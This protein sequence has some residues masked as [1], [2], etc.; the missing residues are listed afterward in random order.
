M[1]VLLVLTC[2]TTLPML[3]LRA[4]ALREQDLTAIADAGDPIRYSPGELVALAHPGAAATAFFLV[5]AGEVMLLP[6][7]LQIPPGT[8]QLDVSKVQQGAVTGVV[9]LVGW[10]DQRKAV[11]WRGLLVWKCLLQA[12]TALTCAA[13]AGLSLL[14]PHCRNMF[15]VT[16]AMHCHH[17][18]MQNLHAHNCSPGCCN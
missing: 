16:T 13:G 15:A 11:P 4:Q 2:S 10:L 18:C 5:T 9:V 17:S 7:S 6:A 8:T 1:R 12:S 3:L 14:L